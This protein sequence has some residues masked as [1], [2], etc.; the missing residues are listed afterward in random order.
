M[1]IF[2]SIG[3]IVFMVWLCK[4]DEWKAR[5]RV[6]PPGY[7]TDWGKM[8]EDRT[9]KGMSQTEIYKKQLRGGYDVKD[10][11]YETWEERKARHPHDN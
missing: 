2:L 7:H 1:E 9:L 3:F 5:N 4:K 11:K 6:P 8:S 10:K